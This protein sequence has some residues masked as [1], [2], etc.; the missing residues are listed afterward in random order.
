MRR[1]RRRVTACERAGGRRQTFVDDLAW[2]YAI[3]VGPAPPAPADDG[4]KYSLTGS[5][6]QFTL[7]QIRNR[8]GPADWYPGDHPAMPPVVAQG[9]K[10]PASGRARCATIRTARGGPRT[11]ASSA[12]PKE[13]FIRQMYDFKAGHRLSA[14][15]RKPNT[16][17]MAG[18][19]E[20]R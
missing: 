2:A 10:P 19:A 4:T 3:T 1:S 8:M 16:P 11:R 13:Y 7:D 15:P 6:S 18:F 17:I 14:D 9:A 20:A 5:T 12:M